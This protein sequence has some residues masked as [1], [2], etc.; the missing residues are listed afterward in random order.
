M[1]YHHLNTFKRT[2]IE[3]LSK[4]GYSTKQ[5]AGQL[6]RHQQAITREFKRNHTTFYQVGWQRN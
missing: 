2:R 4:T 6:N 3:V 5:I 1:S